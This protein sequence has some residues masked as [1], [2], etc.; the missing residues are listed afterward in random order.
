MDNLSQVT[1]TNFKLTKDRKSCIPRVPVN[2][3]CSKRQKA[4]KS[5]IPR[6]AVIYS[7]QPK[8]P[9]NENEKLSIASINHFDLKKDKPSRVPVNYCKSA[10]DKRSYIPRINPAKRIEPKQRKSLDKP[11]SSLSGKSKIPVLISTKKPKNSVTKIINS[12]KKSDNKTRTSIH[13]R[14]CTSTHVRTCTSTHIRTST[15]N[16][17]KK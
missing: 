12:T 5:F 15:L 14:T 11:I 7:K 3:T 13:I 10:K 8:Q 1:I 17:I 9:D 4:G 6:V 2:Y 16:T